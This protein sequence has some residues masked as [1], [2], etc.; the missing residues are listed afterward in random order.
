MPCMGSIPAMLV[1]CMASCGAAAGRGEMAKRRPQPPRPST[2]QKQAPPH[3][4][5]LCIHQDASLRC[6]DAYTPSWR[7]RK[8]RCSS[9]KIRLDDI[10]L[11]HALG[12]E[13]GAIE[14]NGVAHDID[15]ALLVAIEQGHN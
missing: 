10:L 7:S 6:L 14:C 5:G 3:A 11:H 15:K 8:Q 9:Q 13:K 1:C 2:L 4:G 12:I